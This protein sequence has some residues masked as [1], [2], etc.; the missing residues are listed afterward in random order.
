MTIK[1]VTTEGGVFILFLPPRPSDED[2][3]MTGQGLVLLDKKGRY[4]LRNSKR[5]GQLLCP[6][7]EAEWPLTYPVAER[8]R[9]CEFL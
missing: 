6:R 9:Q 4:P 5:L 8:E 2:D 1:I 7:G 3:D